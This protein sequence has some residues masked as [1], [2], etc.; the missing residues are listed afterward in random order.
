[1]SLPKTFVPLAVFVASHFV[2]SP[3]VHA[4]GSPF[5]RGDANDDGTVDIADPVSTL[6]YLF[7]GG[8]APSCED[9]ADANDD[10]DLDI[11][12]P[13]TSL[14]WLFLGGAEPP[15]PGPSEC[16]PDP[17]Q[18][19]LACEVSQNCAEP[20]PPCTTPEEWIPKLVHPL[21]DEN[22][23]FVDDEIEAMDA[24]EA[25]NVLLD[26]NRCPSPAD[27]EELSAFG[28]LGY[29]G[30]FISVVE[31]KSVPVGSA[32][33]LGSD[34]RVA[35][36][37]LERD[38]FP[39]LDLSATTVSVRTGCH[40]P[41]TV[42]DSAP[43][44]D[45]RGVAI[46]VIDS[47]IDFGHESLPLSKFVSG[48]NLTV[49]GQPQT[50]PDDIL[51]HGTHVAG[52]A[53]G[54]GGASGLYR[55]MAPGAG[56]VS[57]K[58]VP[59]GTGCA[60]LPLVL[61]ALDL[62]ILNRTL[63][64]IGVINISLG[65]Q[66]SSNGTEALPQLVNRAVR[67]GMAVV[68]AMGNESRTPWVP[69]PA[70][71]DAAISVAASFDAFTCPQNDD[72]IATSSNGGPRLD[73][74]DTEALDE[75][76]PDL[77]APGLLITSAG[78][79]TTSGYVSF[80][81]TSMAAP[82]VAGIAALVRQAIP[83][84][85][86]AQV[87]T[88]LLQ[89]TLALPLVPPPPGRAWGPRAG[90]GLVNGWAAALAAANPT[91][92]PF[93]F[94][95][96][97]VYSGVGR[98]S[99][100]LSDIA[101]GSLD[102]VAFPT[103]QDLDLIVANREEN[104]FTVLRNNGSGNFVPWITK[105]T[106]ATPTAVALGDVVRGPELEVVVACQGSGGVAQ[107]WHSGVGGHQDLFSESATIPVGP[108]LHDLQLARLNGDYWPDIVT[109]NRLSNDVSLAYNAFGNAVFSSERRYAAHTN[110]IA[111]AVADLNQDGRL[112]LAVANSSS[113]DV[114]ILANQRHRFSS[115]PARYTLGTSSP[116]PA[117]ILAAD[118]DGDDAPDVVVAFEN[119]GGVYVLL[120]NGSG[121]L[122]GTASYPTGRFAGKCATAD[123]DLDGARDLVVPARD[124]R[125]VTLLRNNGT[126][127]FSARRDLDL[128]GGALLNGVP[129]AAATGDFDRDGDMD[130]AVAVDNPCRVLVFMNRVFP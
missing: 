79:D 64:G 103:R 73:D 107:L 101:V 46:A 126:A 100:S 21:L 11:G 119:E 41:N 130:I 121:F 55:G 117:D 7:S 85:T 99:S 22:Q 86:A 128:G 97:V 32:I 57:I 23:N 66:T 20:P 50:R 104:T 109:T 118:F 36:V 58:V 48:W 84:F 18:D 96:P 45:G 92:V 102:R 39:S 69:S 29:V 80:D 120:N 30:P 61:Q 47:G 81:G 43:A 15:A 93:S 129:K 106:L 87:K 65:G 6:S 16:G 38:L 111:V 42:E 2:L 112:D 10:G 17:T 3:E 77:C 72:T 67:R 74:G 35:F 98:D 68:I 94:A 91:R 44:I 37:E 105:D 60:P 114:S 88:R 5:R 1:M 78:W 122:I 24:G 89:T 31:L 70:S 62:C 71:A 53:A 12:D 113:R 63:L 82:H 13:I 76:K 95:P 19:A 52:I 28:T 110:P 9:A 34:P 125:V 108:D 40:S 4:Q 49:S 123:L 59:D 127:D 116:P 33:E 90:R 83:S 25:V 27:I 56:L 75:L 14:T 51:G 115:P 54:T 8:A 124:D 26:L